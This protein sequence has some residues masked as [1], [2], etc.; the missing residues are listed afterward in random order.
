MFNFCDPYTG[1]PDVARLPKLNFYRLEQFYLAHKLWRSFNY[2]H[3]QY[4]MLVVK[5]NKPLE[6]PKY[7]E[8]QPG[9]LESFSVELLEIP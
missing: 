7:V 1:A 3:P 8:G 9:A 4:G 6:T 2:N 5:F